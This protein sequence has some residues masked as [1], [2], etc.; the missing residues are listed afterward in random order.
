MDVLINLRKD[1][2]KIYFSNDFVLRLSLLDDAGERLSLPEDVIVS[3]SIFVRGSDNRYAWGPVQGVGPGNRAQITRAGELEIYVN[4]HSLSAGRLWIEMQFDIPD[5][6]Y[7]DG[8]QHLTGRYSLD[9]ELTVNTGDIPPSGVAAGITLS[10]LTIRETE[11]MRVMLE[12][13]SEGLEKLL[14]EEDDS[15][16]SESPEGSDVPEVERVLG[17]TARIGAELR[18]S[19]DREEKGGE[20]KLYCGS[21]MVGRCRGLEVPKEEYTG[22]SPF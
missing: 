16:D 17:L 21:T 10:G 9:I 3:G 20:I 6:R 8:Y 7:D 1:M 5:E 19:R 15:E 4:N 13:I 18:K 22:G 12:R 11:A 14:A 2:E